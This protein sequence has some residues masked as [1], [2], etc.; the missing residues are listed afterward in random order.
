M[1][2]SIV[3][4]LVGDEKTGKTDL[5]LTAPKPIFHMEFD[6]GGFKRVAW[7]YQK[8]IEDESIRTKPYFTPDHVDSLS[9][10]DLKR[11]IAVRGL[12][13]PNVKVKP[14]TGHMLTG[15]KELW[16]DNFLTDYITAL[17][18]SPDTPEYCRTIVMDT[19]TSVWSLCH[20][21]GLQEKQEAAARDGRTR[22]SLIQ[23][24]YGPYNE[25]MRS[26][27]QAARQSD[28]NLILIHHTKD[29]REDRMVTGGN[30]QNIIVGQTFDGW[31]RVRPII[32]VELW[33]SIKIP[34]R[35]RLEDATEKRKT[36]MDVNI[37][38][39]GL[40]RDAAGMTFTD[41]TWDTI[42]AYIDLMR[43]PT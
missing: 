10:E 29:K 13:D 38:L 30:V 6:A 36:T 27:I 9:L 43:Q 16:Y 17:E 25:R 39:C 11:S 28:K 5:A 4:S 40:T 14:T 3:V 15:Y 26:V 33:F 42:M 21:T 8:E 32:D 22:D 34:E 7:R 23:I 12:K 2:E 37:S 24:E 35:P 20:T 31:S 19:F 1:D 41:P 18:A